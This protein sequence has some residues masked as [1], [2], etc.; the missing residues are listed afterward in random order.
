MFVDSFTKFVLFYAV[1]G[2]SAEETVQC[3]QRLVEAYGLPRRLVTDRGT[4][5]TANSFTT[6]CE[7]QG[8]THVLASSRHP[9]T[10]GQ[11][12]RVHSALMS[13]LITA[14]VEPD[15]W[16]LELMKV[17]NDLNSS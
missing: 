11:V 2:T 1:A 12:E 4:S 15:E 3:V 9:Q 5:F 16:D 6:Y 17:Q 8:I 7:N 14:C 10:N 13:A